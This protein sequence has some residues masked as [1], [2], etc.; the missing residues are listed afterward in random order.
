MMRLSG[1]GDYL[2]EVAND[3]MTHAGKEDLRNQAFEWKDW[4]NRTIKQQ[5]EG[6]VAQTLLKLNVSVRSPRYL[7]AWAG[8]E[9]M[10]PHDLA[11]FLSLIQGLNM[12]DPM[13]PDFTFGDYARS[14]WDAMEEVKA[15][16]HKAGSAIRTELVLLVKDLIKRRQRVDVVQSIELSGVTSG[17]MGLL[18]V[19]AVD[20]K[21]MQVPSSRLFNLARIVNH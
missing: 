9:V 14:K 15:F 6:V 5:G 11:T 7:W 8:D 1:S 10:A 12:L 4:L 21:S 3:L 16:H 2:D 20:S 13:P 17:K 19:S 18:R